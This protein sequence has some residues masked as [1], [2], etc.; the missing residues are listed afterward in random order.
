MDMKVTLKTRLTLD[1]VRAAMN[2]GA[3]KGEE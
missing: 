2:E 1:E 3:R